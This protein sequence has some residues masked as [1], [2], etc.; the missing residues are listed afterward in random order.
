MDWN[1]RSKMD[2]VH[3]R[4]MQFSWFSTLKVE[5]CAMQ[6]WLQKKEVKYVQ[7][8]ECKPFHERTHW[9]SV[10]VFAI[11]RQYNLPRKYNSF[12]GQTILNTRKTKWVQSDCKRKKNFFSHIKTS[13]SV[14]HT[15]EI[16]SRIYAS[17]ILN[18]DNRIHTNLHM[19]VK[20][21]KS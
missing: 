21:L 14:T 17:C 20:W 19:C 15:V 10:V 3:E 1:L 6:Q 12:G 11:I 8:S 2:V 5:M 13:F 4:V 18:G 16:S 7:S 9:D